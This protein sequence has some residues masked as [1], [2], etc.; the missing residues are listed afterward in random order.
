VKVK[1]KKDRKHLRT[2]IQCYLLPKEIW[3]HQ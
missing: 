3:I 2:W 1:V